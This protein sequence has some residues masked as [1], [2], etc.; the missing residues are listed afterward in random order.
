MSGSNAGKANFSIGKAIALEFKL[1]GWTT[2]IFSNFGPN[3][4]EPG[5]LIETK[6]KYSPA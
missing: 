4:D 5:V 1:G 6:P 3:I 2:I